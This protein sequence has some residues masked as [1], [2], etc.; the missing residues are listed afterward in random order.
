MKHPEGAKRRVDRVP[1]FHPDERRD[2]SLLENPFDVVSGER[3]LERF[4]VPPH[5]A[6]DHVDLFESGGDGLLARHRGRNV[7]RPELPADPSRLQPRDVGVY[8]RLRLA[9]VQLLQIAVGCR[10]PQLPRIVIVPVDERGR[11]VQPPCSFEEVI[12]TSGDANRNECQD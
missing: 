4:G 10:F 9:D 11:P 5:H 12:L 3:Q 7:D 2:L 6:M 1:T 8:R